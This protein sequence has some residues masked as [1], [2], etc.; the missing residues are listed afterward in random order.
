[1]T[2]EPSSSST[3]SKGTIQLKKE[4]GLFSAVSFILSIMIGSGIFVS[5]ASALKYSGSVGMCLIVWVTCGIISLLVPRSGSEYAYF[6]DSFGPLHKFWGH[7]PA[8][9]YSWIMILVIRPAEVAILVL[10]FSQYLCQPILDALCIITYINVS[11]VK[12]YVKVQ[13]VFG[14]FKIL[15]CLVVIVGGLNEIG[16]GNTTNLL[17]GFEGTTTS[18]KDFA[19]AFYCGLWAYDG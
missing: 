12:M 1:M 10:T 13:N 5:P 4:L 3:K 16:C 9:V 15:A 18:P 19:L 7:L 2:V 6:V 14:L 11:S 17:K 8:F